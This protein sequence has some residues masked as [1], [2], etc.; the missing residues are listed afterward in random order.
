MLRGCSRRKRPWPIERLRVQ[1]RREWCARGERWGDP[2]HDS[3][4]GEDDF[5]ATVSAAS[6]S[7]SLGA[8]KQHLPFASIAI[9]LGRSGTTS[10]MKFRTARA[11]ASASCWLD[12][13]GTDVVGAS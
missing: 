1:G 12:A 7:S 3:R 2:S 13:I 9:T 10:R 6:D 4:A 8:M 11:R 5:H